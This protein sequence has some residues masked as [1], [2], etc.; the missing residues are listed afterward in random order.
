MLK[1][2]ALY[3]GSGTGRMS[4]DGSTDTPAIAIAATLQ[5]VQVGPLLEA[6]A[7]S[8]RLRGTGKLELDVAG[9]GRSQRAIISALSGKGALDLKDGEITGFNAVGLAQN[10]LA[11]AGGGG[12]NITRFGALTGTF[13][14]E[15]GILRNDDLLLTDGPVPVKGAG[16]AN[17][18]ERTLDYRAVVQ[19]APAAVPILITGPWDNLHYGPDT[20][21]IVKGI[22]QDPAKALQQL[23]QA[24]PGTQPG[25]NPLKSLFPR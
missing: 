9:K 22:V 10:A 15:Q 7:G 16:T 6:L 25:S 18:P 14:I 13:R 8:S 12:G 19:L 21:A 17:L 1:H 11:V 3:G 23:Q 2:S 5:K 24:I 4:L 20:G